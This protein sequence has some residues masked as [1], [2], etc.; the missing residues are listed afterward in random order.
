MVQYKG[1]VLVNI[2]YNPDEK[3]TDTKGRGNWS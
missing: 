1:T 2:K 3:N